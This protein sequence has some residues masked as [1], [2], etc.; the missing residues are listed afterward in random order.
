MLREVRQAFEGDED[1]FKF[2]DPT[3]KVKTYD[4]VVANVVD[5]MFEYAIEYDVRFVSIDRGYV[6]T[7]GPSI[8]VSFGLA[9][10]RRNKEG[11]SELWGS[12]KE[13]L[14][15]PFYCSLWAKNTRA[16]EWL[17]K[18]GMRYDSTAEFNGHEIITLCHSED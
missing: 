1:I 11:L 13:S 2:F 4:D 9:P 3:A 8:L 6:F 16:I 14:T 10:E 7:A 5:K 17:K 15:S 12:I 18:C